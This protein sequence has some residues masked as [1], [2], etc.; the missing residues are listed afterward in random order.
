MTISFS[1]VYSNA[2]CSCL[3]EPEI[4]EISQS[5]HKMYS[6]NI[7]NFQESATILN[8][9]TK[10]SPET[11]WRHFVSHDKFPSSIA[12]N[13]ISFDKCLCSSAANKIS[14]DKFLSFIAENGMSC[15]KFL[16]SNVP[17]AISCERYLSLPRFVDV[18]KAM[19]MPLHIK[20]CLVRRSK[21]T[22][23]NF[24]IVFLSFWAYESKTMK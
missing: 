3:F 15:D 22:V 13:K 9:S 5:Y 14:C 19:M 18:M 12:D 11:Y 1:R 7:L 16:C 10:K 6:N 23:R 2:C 20:S 24:L 8:A 4:I 17:N 21:Y